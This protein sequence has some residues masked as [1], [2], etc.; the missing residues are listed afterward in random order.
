MLGAYFPKITEH[1]SLRYEFAEWQNAWY[2][3]GNYGDGLTHDNLILG[4]WGAN[5]RV[6][7][8]AVGSNN[9]TAKLIY[10]T[11]KHSLITTL[12]QVQNEQYSSIDYSPGQELSLDYSRAFSRYRFGMKLTSGT[13]VFDQN[14]SQLSGYV[15][16]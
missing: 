16:W 2:T 13:S 10:A 14:Y 6:F 11:Q 3:N 5:E 4:H 15:Q 7:S 8:S 1:L 12:K 9:H